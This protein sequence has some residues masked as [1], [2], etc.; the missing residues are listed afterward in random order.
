[1]ERHDLVEYDAGVKRERE[2]TER[3]WIAQFAADFKRV[4]QMDELERKPNE[5]IGRTDLEGTPEIDPQDIEVF[6]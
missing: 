3:E 2:E 6:K 1:M 5:V 4:A